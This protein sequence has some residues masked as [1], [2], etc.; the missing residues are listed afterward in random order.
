MNEQITASQL[1]VIIDRGDQPDEALGVISREEALQKA[2]DLGVD[3]VLIAEKSDPPVCKI[4]DYGKLRY[5]KEKKKK[6]QMK[7]ARSNEIKEVKMS[8]KIGEADYQ[9]RRRAAV[10]FV[11]AGMRVKLVIQFRG[12]EQQH[13]NLG[14]DLIAR[15]ISELEEEGAPVQKTKTVREGRD[16]T[17]ILSLKT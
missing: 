16:L 13:I 5:A 15:F 10:K 6:E 17:T 2:D 11:Q 7:K 1:R 3:L 8:Y 9:V 4:V 14:D 12:R